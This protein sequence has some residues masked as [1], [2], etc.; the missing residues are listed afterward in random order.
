L[1]IKVTMRIG[2]GSDFGTP[3]GNRAFRLEPVGTTRP[4]TTEPIT[5]GDIGW[6]IFFSASNDADEWEHATKN[7]T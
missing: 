5:A 2:F 3:A 6:R 1:Q 4:L 7:S